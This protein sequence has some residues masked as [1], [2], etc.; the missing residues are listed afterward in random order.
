MREQEERD[1]HGASI[2]FSLYSVFVATRTKITETKGRRLKGSGVLVLE[3][4][5]AESHF[6]RGGHFYVWEEHC[7]C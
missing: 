7:C 3:L 5:E 2:Q 6:G 1:N 4:F